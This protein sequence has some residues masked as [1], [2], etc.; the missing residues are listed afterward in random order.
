[1]FNEH[2]ILKALCHIIWNWHL[3]VECLVNFM[4]CVCS[5]PSD[6]S[7][8]S[9]SQSLSIS[10]S[11]SSNSAQI[12]KSTEISWKF[13]EVLDFFRKFQTSP[14]FQTLIFFHEISSYLFYLISSIIS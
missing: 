6:L 14:K 8:C 1:M 2:L 3:L 4:L 13:S 5:S 12:L 10:M 9:A 11:H 7:L